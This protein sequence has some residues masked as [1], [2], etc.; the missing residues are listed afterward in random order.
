MP[1]LKYKKPK[2]PTVDSKAAAE[3]KRILDRQDPPIG[4]KDA[5]DL[6]GVSGETMRAVVNDNRPPSAGV[7]NGLARALNL[8]KGEV[9]HLFNLLKDDRTTIKIKKAADAVGQDNGQRFA[10]IF[11]SLTDEQHFLNASRLF[12]N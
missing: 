11:T 6:V 4:Y 7:I 9:T 5:S 1:V 2:T 8:S 3:I 10:D 12:L